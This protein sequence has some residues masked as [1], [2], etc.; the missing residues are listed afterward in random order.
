MPIYNAYL[1]SSNPAQTT[2]NPKAQIS[3]APK[4]S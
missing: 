1:F 3:L 2:Y 4:A